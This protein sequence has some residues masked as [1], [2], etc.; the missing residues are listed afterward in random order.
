MDSARLPHGLVR[1]EAAEMPPGVLQQ[2][3]E[4]DQ[5]LWLRLPEGQRAACTQWSLAGLREQFAAT[6]GFF[7]GHWSV[8]NAVQ[9][10]SR[11][12]WPTF[13]QLFQQQHAE[14]TALTLR[15]RTAPLALPLFPRFPPHHAVLLTGAPRDDAA[16]AAA[17][18][19][20]PVGGG[21]AGWR[22]APAGGLVLL[23]H[24]AGRCAGAGGVPR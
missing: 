2:L 17:R 6:P 1:H 4:R 21:S 11:P 12:G 15:L 7:S 9:V 16:A 22:L 8:E 13:W 14:A 24:P 18:P 3:Y 20:R 23:G 5:L 10:R 19:G